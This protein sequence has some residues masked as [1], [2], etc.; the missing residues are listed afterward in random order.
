MDSV[1]SVLTVLVVLSCS[2]QL[3]VHL[4][5]SLIE[6]WTRWTALVVCSSAHHTAKSSA[7]RVFDTC[8]TV[9]VMSF[10]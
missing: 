5:T 7:C 6:F 1:K 4:H 9:M 3:S 10:M 8:G 2:S